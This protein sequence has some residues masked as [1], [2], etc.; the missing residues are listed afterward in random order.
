MKTKKKPQNQSDQEEENKNGR[1][2][3]Y[4]KEYCTR[5]DSF[6]EVEAYTL[7]ELKS[8][9]EYDVAG[10]VRKESSEKKMIPNKMPTV[11]RFAESIGISTFTFYE[12]VKKYTDFSN[13]FTRAKERQK[14]YLITLGLAGITPPAAFIFVS[15]NMTDMKPQGVDPYGA[16]TV[17][18]PVVVRKGPDRLDAPIKGKVRIMT[19][20]EVQEAIPAQ[21]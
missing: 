19:S 15:S 2:T 11:F 16:Q 1:P 20:N 10:N 12:W 8:S 9:K 4:K 17:I 6:F 5:M 21:K 13:A 7:V 18:V 14:E 3:K